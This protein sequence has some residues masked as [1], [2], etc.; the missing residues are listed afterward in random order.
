MAQL[1]TAPKL[2][3]ACSAVCVVVCACQAGVSMLLAVETV[4]VQGESSTGVHQTLAG[5]GEWLGAALG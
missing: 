3:L 2:Q 5:V 1:F 4:S